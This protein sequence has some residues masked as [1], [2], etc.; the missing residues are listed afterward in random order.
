MVER[1]CLERDV[2][3]YVSIQLSP[4][5]E[6]TCGWL[7]SLAKGQ[8]EE[9]SILLERPLSC[10]WKR[11]VFERLLLLGRLLRPVGSPA[12]RG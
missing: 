11:A 6:S 3:A 4:G 5:S 1:E 9:D 12:Q 10:T 2:N 7:V 8:P